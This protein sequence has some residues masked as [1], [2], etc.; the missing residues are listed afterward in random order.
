MQTFARRFSNVPWSTSHSSILSSNAQSLLVTGVAGCGKTELLVR[1][2]AKDFL[3]GKKVLVVTL[4][5]AVRDEL[6]A[7]LNTLL[8]RPLRV[9]G[10]SHKTRLGVTMER[11]A[12]VRKKKSCSKE[13]EILS[14]LGLFTVDNEN[15]STSC[16][17]LQLS[18]IDGMVHQALMKF[19]ENWLR[20][21][22]DRHSLKVRRLLSLLKE[23]EL[24]SSNFPV[25][26]DGKSA[27]VLLCDELQD[28]DEERALLLATMAASGLKRIQ[29]DS[30][31]SGPSLESSPSYLTSFKSVAVGDRLQSVFDHAIESSLDNHPFN[32]WLRATNKKTIEHE[33]PTC[34]RCP[35]SHIRLVNLLMGKFQSALNLS[36]I[37]SVRKD[38]PG[39]RPILFAHEPTGKNSG[40]TAAALRVVALVSSYFDADKSLRP[41]DVAIVMAKINNSAVMGVLEVKLEEEFVRRFGHGKDEKLAETVVEDESGIS[42]AV[43]ESFVPRSKSGKRSWVHYFATEAD[44]ARITIKWS[45]AKNKAAL[46][47]VHAIKGRSARLVVFLGVTEGAIPREARVF[48]HVE[49]VDQSILNVGLTRSIQYLAIGFAFRRPSRYLFEMKEELNKFAALTWDSTSDGDVIDSSIPPLPPSTKDDVE[50]SIVRGYFEK[51]RKSELDALR[52]DWNYAASTYLM[53]ESGRPEHLLFPV[54]LLADRN[55]KLCDGDEAFDPNTFSRRFLPGSAPVAFPSSFDTEDD[56]IA[57]IVGVMG[58]LGLSL[59][60][61]A[62]G[63]SSLNVVIKALTEGSGTSSENVEKETSLVRLPWCSFD[64]VYTNDDRALASYWDVGANERIATGQ[65]TPRAW[66]RVVSELEVNTN[67]GSQNPAYKIITEA[68]RNDDGLKESKLN[69]EGIE[70]DEGV[71]DENGDVGYYQGGALMKPVLLV[72]SLLRDSPQYLLNG[73]QTV[74]ESMQSSRGVLDKESGAEK[75]SNNFLQEGTIAKALWGASVVKMLLTQRVRRPRMAELID[76]CPDTKAGWWSRLKNNIEIVAAELS[77]NVR[78]SEWD[79]GLALEL[80]TEEEDRSVLDEMTIDPSRESA[81][82]G[83]TGFCD[84]YCRGTRTLL[85]VKVGLGGAQRLPAPLWTVQCVIYASMESDEF[86]PYK[87]FAPNK[88]VIVDLG[89]GSCWTHVGASNTSLQATARLFLKKV[90][91]RERYRKEHVKKILRLT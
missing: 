73:F 39:S 55:Q 41:S 7:R 18:T 58:E 20:Q 54:R 89:S 29:V 26:I 14:S 64:L 12:E 2:A 1:S 15:T 72:D 16:G 45:R 3:L 4:V 27:D 28:V 61:K 22:N 76:E 69:Q 66:Q 38:T 65:M 30:K 68:Y 71:V 86:P 63:V 47:S 52:P 19:D 49:L 8:P 82:V 75:R 51:L 46:C 57:C 34:F 80:S 32:T 44:A 91:L 70:N 88:L 40:A 87:A 53:T 81:R 21:N 5:S 62:R 11:I 79:F 37:I 9:I 85:E 24:I 77:S 84:A 25:M 48:R 42:E 78:S 36:P 23:D 50:A 10:S 17:S 35:D 83:V 6:A 33:L 90:L 13:F 31:A 56:L 74:L 60:M 67:S 43:E 59:A